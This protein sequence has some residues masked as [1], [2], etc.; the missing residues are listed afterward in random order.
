MLCPSASQLATSVSLERCSLHKVLL[1]NSMALW[2]HQSQIRTNQHKQQKLVF[3]AGQIPPSL[4]Y[5]LASYCFFFF[6][7]SYCYEGSISIF[8]GFYVS[9]VL[10]L[11]FSGV[12]HKKV[13]CVTASNWQGACIRF[14]NLIEL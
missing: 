6:F 1:V 11:Q 7:A 13:R 3:L 4:V 10:L 9:I 12:C 8:P 14:N 2:F 5:L